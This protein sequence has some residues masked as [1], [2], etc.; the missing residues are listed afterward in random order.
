MVYVRDIADVEFNYEEQSY[1]A[2]LNGVSGVFVTASRKMGTNIFDVEKQ[3]QPV[4]DQFAKEL[5]KS[6][7]YE[8]EL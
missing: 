8:Q 5:P 3:M 1:I 2:R 4:L 6:I 7:H